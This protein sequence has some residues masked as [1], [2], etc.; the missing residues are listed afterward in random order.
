MIKLNLILLFNH[1]YKKNKIKNYSKINY[2]KIKKYTQLIKKN[3]YYFL[4]IFS[5]A[6]KIYILLFS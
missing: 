1:I 3:K 5:G 2:I 6:E 4:T